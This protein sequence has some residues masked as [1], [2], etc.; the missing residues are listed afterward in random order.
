[1]SISTKLK[2]L[3]I[4]RERLAERCDICHQTDA[5]DPINN[6]CSRCSSIDTALMHKSTLFQLSLNHIFNYGNNGAN[7]EARDFSNFNESVV[8]VWR[9]RKVYATFN[10]LILMAAFVTLPNIL[11]FYRSEFSI[12]SAIFLWFLSSLLIPALLI[13]IN[14]RLLSCPNCNR[15]VKRVHLFKSVNICPNCQIQL[16]ERVREDY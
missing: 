2:E 16:K 6:H 9:N 7:T 3:I 13:F 5:F 14:D 12:W 10:A 1:M 8:I 4:K 15:R 11:F